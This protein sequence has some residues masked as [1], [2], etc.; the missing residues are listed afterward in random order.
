VCGA[1]VKGKENYKTNLK[2]SIMHE[3]CVSDSLQILDENIVDCINHL[4]ERFLEL[5]SKKDLINMV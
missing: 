1:I 2:V 5:K 3:D 4:L